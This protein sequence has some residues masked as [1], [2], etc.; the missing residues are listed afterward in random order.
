MFSLNEYPNSGED[1]LPRCEEHGKQLEK[2][3][4]VL[5]DKEATEV[6]PPGHC[7]VCN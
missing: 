1:G 4:V 5:F 6:L 7:W 3:E 2:K